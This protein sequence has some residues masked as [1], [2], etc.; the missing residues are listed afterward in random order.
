MIKTTKY[1]LISDMHSGSKFAVRK[2]PK[3]YTQ[4]AIRKIWNEMISDLNTQTLDGAINLGDNCDGRDRHGSGEYN[5]TNN[6]LEQIDINTDL[7]D[8]IPV[9]KWFFVQGSPYH[10]DQNVSSDALVAQRM[11]GRFEEEMIVKVGQRRIHCSHAI[12]VSMASPAYRT[13]PIAR[14]MMLATINEK[15]YGKFDLIA[16]GHAHYFVRVSFGGSSGIIC[17]CWKGRDAFASRRSLAMMPHIGYVLLDINKDGILIEPHVYS[18]KG[19]S[20]V[21]EVNAE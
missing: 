6:I 5:D 7:L 16:R 18:L 3:N 2:H 9:K 21:P 4:Q 8:E 14:E 19:K 1:L 11:G 17:P 12:G 13:T 20:L 10:T 15:E